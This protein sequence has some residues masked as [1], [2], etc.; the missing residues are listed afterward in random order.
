[1]SELAKKLIAENKRT[2]ATFLDLGR[3][4]VKE[5]PDEVGDLVWL[6]F[7]SLASEWKELHGQ[8]F[9][10][11]VSSNIGTH[12]HLT[13]L[14]PL[15]GLLNLK[16]LQLSGT[17]ISDLSPLRN[18]TKLQSLDCSGTPVTDLKPI[19]NLIA[20]QSLNCSRT[21]IDDL[22]PIKGLLALRFLA[23]YSTQIADLTPLRGLL[24][25]RSLDCY[26]TRVANLAPLKYL[27]NLQ[28]LDC[29][30][31]QVTDLSPLIPL[32]REDLGVESGSNNGGG[33]HVWGCPLTNPPHEIV[34]R[35]TDAILNYFDELERSK[36]KVDHLYE[37][38]ML[39]LGEG[40]SGKTSLIQRLYHP[41]IK[42]L[43]REDQSTKG[44]IIEKHDFPLKNGRTFRLNV[45]DFGGQQIYHATHQFFLTQRSL[46]ILLDDTG[47]DSK[48]V[49]DEGFRYWL[50]LL[51]VFGG[52]SP[53]LIFQN[54]KGGRSKAI[55]FDG[56]QSQY[57]NV[58]E[59]YSGNLDRLDSADRIRKGI[60]YFAENLPHIG[61]EL[62]A[63]WLIIRGEIEELSKKKHSI[64]VEEYLALCAPHFDGDDKRA[65]HL[66]SYLHDL[67]VF[68]HF[69]DD[70]VLRKT[71]ILQNEWATT[72]VFRILD[73]EIVKKNLGRFT[74]A[75]CARLWQDSV[76]RSKH[77]ELL[78][79]MEKFEIC[80][81]LR[82]ENRPTWLAPQL[83]P[84]DR[85]AE[86]KDWGRPGDLV[87]RY[88]YHFLPKGML[89]RLTVRLHRYVRDPKMAWVDG[90]LF[91]E[92]SLREKATD[93]LV[94]ILPA[95]DE[96]ELRARGPESKELISVVSA[97]LDA[98]ND[99]FKGLRERVNKR[100]PCNCEAC[101]AAATPRFFDYK[102][103][104]RFRE[105]G[106]R[107]IVCPERFQKVRV[108]ELLD[109]IKLPEPPATFIVARAPAREHITPIKIFLA[110]SS[111]LQDDRDKF[112]QRIRQHNDDLVKEGCH[113]QIVRW[114]NFFNAMS[115]IRLQNE[116]NEAIRNCDVFVSL[117]STKVGQFTEEEFD[118][119]HV[120]FSTTRKQP[121]IYTFFK[122]ATVTTRNWKKEDHD[123]LERFQNKLK[124][125]GHYPTYYKNDDDLNLQFLQ[126]LPTIRE[127][128]RL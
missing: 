74:E 89:S 88:K 49:S 42:E 106:E 47:K 79:L 34:S 65:F 19:G 48:S 53:T 94:Q 44:I 1:M 97:D 13:S 115:E 67:G 107:E 83:L 2:K 29:S 18:L 72:A 33:I 116:Y 103:L 24:A 76:Y 5:L 9:E 123:S 30:H 11:R 114:E 31:T 20:L 40:R 92:P 10:E 108:I 32:I 63:V 118:V 52:H 23:C 73:D 78:A 126:Q 84:P 112:E 35:G 50:E 6:E 77:S 70:S 62:P 86:L 36:G 110:S 128:L 120:R 66:S 104:L 41:E 4:S 85:P 124:G 91:R 12:N 87:L 37:A 98:L 81:R 121:L 8:H 59:I 99:T 46:Y 75:D 68:L 109:G 93:V 39:V 27:R 17:G 125:F 51:D 28:R 57:T 96:I 43:P 15:H 21:Q 100:I 95:G 127:K 111:E 16:A 58:K 71:V 56:I 119:A 82:D 90:V 113:L 117:F 26:G 80:Y 69:Q 61:E 45:W 22:T 105:F 3:C 38:K 60:E 102:E 64:P 55:A 25:L 122:E 101:K 54:E 7:L 14:A